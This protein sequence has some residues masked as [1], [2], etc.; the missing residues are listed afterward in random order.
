MN[1]TSCKRFCKKPKALSESKYCE[2][3]CI[4]TDDKISF[5]CDINLLDESLE[6]E[7][8]LLNCMFNDIEHF[9]ACKKCPLKCSRNENPKQKEVA[10]QGRKLEA[11]IED[12]KKS[13][14]PVNINPEKLIQISKSFQENEENLNNTKEAIEAVNI[15][16][17][18]LEGLSEGRAPDPSSFAI[19]SHHFKR[20]FVKK[21]RK[22][23]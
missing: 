15:A 3:W 20:K 5:S 13:S 19:I 23:T 16:R 18:I 17:N 6:E 14:L 22:K 4:I 10:E 11:I 9:S 12:L 2:G 7:K 21:S 1:K 8:N